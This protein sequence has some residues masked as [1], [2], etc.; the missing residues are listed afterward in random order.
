MDEVA[1]RRADALGRP[2]IVCGFA[3]S[4]SAQVLDVE[5]GGLVP[6]GQVMVE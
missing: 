2:V 3:G 1:L 4:G 5:D 6:R